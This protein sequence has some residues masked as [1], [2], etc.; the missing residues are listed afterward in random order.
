VFVE[1]SVTL[2]SR[3]AVL[4]GLEIWERAFLVDIWLKDV[5]N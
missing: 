4:D 1:T 2:L 5:E 3:V